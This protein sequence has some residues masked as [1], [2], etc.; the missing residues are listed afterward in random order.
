MTYNMLYKRFQSI[1][2]PIFDRHHQ[3]LADAILLMAECMTIHSHD[4]NDERVVKSFSIVSDHIRSI[5]FSHFSAEEE[6]MVFVNY[7]GYISHK[8]R[9]EKFI[10]EFMRMRNIIRSEDSSYIYDMFVFLFNW[11]INH[12]NAEDI[13]LREFFKGQE[14]VNFVIAN[15]N[16]WVIPGNKSCVGLTHRVL[17]MLRR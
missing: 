3:G 6:F 5:M 16:R 17:N 14:V 13:Q 4:S 12:V 1:G 15:E 2:I 8:K 11:L 10:H 7:P 9:H